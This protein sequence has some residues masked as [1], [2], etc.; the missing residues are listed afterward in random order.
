M[1]DAKSRMWA[2]TEIMNRI[3]GKAPQHVIVDESGAE[4]TI[5]GKLLEALQLSPHDRRKRI[6]DLEKKDTTR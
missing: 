3:Y 6:S 4:P 5:E 2:A 1:D